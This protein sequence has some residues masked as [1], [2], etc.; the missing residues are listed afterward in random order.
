MQDRLNHFTKKVTMTKNALFYL[1]LPCI[2]NSVKSLSNHK[3]LL[4]EEPKFLPFGVPSWFCMKRKLICVAAHFIS[5][6]LVNGIEISRMEFLH[7]LG[8]F[9]WLKC[10]LVKKGNSNLGSWTGYKQ[11]NFPS[12]CL[13]LTSKNLVRQSY[14]CS[15]SALLLPTDGAATRFPI[16]CYISVTNPPLRITQLSS[17]VY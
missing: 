5:S 3:N 11:S 15:F 6:N 13:L 17:S 1:T 2:K 14:N 9:F 8:Q 16:Y 10:V 7:I 4:F 12:L